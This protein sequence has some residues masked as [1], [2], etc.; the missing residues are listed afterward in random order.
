MKTSETPYELIEPTARRVPLIL[1][2]PHCGTGFPEDLED[3]YAPGATAFVDDTDWYLERL[4]DF[5]PALGV[6]MIHAVHSRWVIDLNREPGSTPLYDDGRLITG[7]CPTTDFLGRDIYAKTE[8]EPD[9]AETE[10][11]LENFYRPYHRKIDELISD[12]RN[13]FGRVVFWDGHSIRREVRT[14]RPEP[15][16]DIILGD[17]GGRTADSRFI[18]TA[19]ETLRSG[20]F[21]V[22]HND[23]FRGGYLTRSKGDPEKGVH[24]LQLE[25]AKDLYMSEDETAYDP[26]RAER[27][28]SLLKRTF[29]NLIEQALAEEETAEGA[30]ASRPQ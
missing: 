23:P 6:T 21:E 1:S 7:L 12:L 16:P 17:D 10:R 30:R 22:S 26:E 19:L 27:V 24:A 4:Y 5:A 11:R 8:Y 15:F 13:E 29:E 14:I 28:R 3:L 25:M 20:P 9:E 2:I 18:R